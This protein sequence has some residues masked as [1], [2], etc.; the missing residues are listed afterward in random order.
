MYQVGVLSLNSLKSAAH[1]I[2]QSNEAII[3]RCNERLDQV[4]KLCTETEEEERF[5]H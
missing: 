1:E 5:S 2:L 4:R 3:N